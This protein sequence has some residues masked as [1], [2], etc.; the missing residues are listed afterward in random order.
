V[1]LLACLLLPVALRG[2][3][4]PPTS[5]PG[6]RP[7]YLA[8]D[9]LSRR[10]ATDAWPT[11]HGDYSGRRFSPLTQINKET[12]ATLQLLWQFR[13]VAAPET[14][15]HV[16]GPGAPGQ[17]LFW[18]APSDGFRIGGAPLMV[19]GILYMSAM[20]RAWAVDARSGRQ[21]WSY[22]FKSRGGHHNNASKGM[23]MHGDTVFFETPD[24]YLVALDA[25][26]GREK[27]HKEIAPVEMNY[28]CSTAPLVV[29]DT[30]FTG[31]GGDSIDA[32]LWLDARDVRTGEVKWRWYTTPQKP[33]DPGYDTWPDDYSR[34]HGGGQTWQ[35]LTYDPDLNLVYVATGN[36]NPVGSGHSRPGANLFTCSLVALDADSGAMRWYFQGSPHDTHDWDCTEA[37]VLFDGAWEGQPRKLVAW[38]IRAGYFFVLDRTTGQNLVTRPLGDA[39]FVNHARVGEQGQIVPDPRKAPQIDGA[40]VGPGSATNWPPPTF[41][42][43]TGLFYVGTSESLALWYLVDTS[44]RPAGYGYNTLAIPSDGKSGLRAIDYR[45]GETKWF[46]EGGGA[47]GLLSTAGGLIFGAD[48]RGGFAAFDDETGKILW[49]FP[50]PAQPTNGPSTWMVDGYQVVVT[51]AQDMVYAFALNRPEQ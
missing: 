29:G 1:L 41:S 36:A 9:V 7:H 14:A 49:R 3:Q 13:A 24:C 26:T 31:L 42:P 4:P 40:L 33:G 6:D 43:K 39:R 2:Q 38:A 25:A 15:T 16:G 35:P 23:S 51:A 44:E 8:A 50:T 19:N 47:R 37:P 12:V 48:G 34:R 27:F 10:E 45:T 46:S 20:S 21:I 32:Q 17:P 22:Y 11:Y 28:Y 18:G 30:V 5:A